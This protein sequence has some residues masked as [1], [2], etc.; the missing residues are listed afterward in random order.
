[1]GNPFVLF[2]LDWDVTKR[3]AAAAGRLDEPG[4]WTVTEWVVLIMLFA[5][6]AAILYC[7]AQGLFCLQWPDR[8]P[9]EGLRSVAIT[10]ATDEADANAGAEQPSILSRNQ[11][12]QEFGATRLARSTTRPPDRLAGD[13]PLVGEWNLFF[14]RF[15]FFGLIHLTA[16]VGV[17]MLYMSQVSYDRASVSN[18]VGLIFY[19]LL[20]VQLSVGFWVAVFGFGVN[21]CSKDPVVTACPILAKPVKPKLDRKVAILFPIYNEEVR[22]VLSGLEASMVSLCKACEASN[23]DV[24]VRRFDWH[25]LSD[26]RKADLSEEEAET[27]TAYSKF[28]YATRGVKVFYR[29]RE[30]NTNKKVGNIQE[31]LDRCGDHYDYMIIFDADSMMSGDTIIRMA[32]TICASPQVGII[33]VQCMPVRQ[34][35]LFGR[36]FQFSATM[37]GEMLVQGYSWV[38]LSAGTYIGHNAIINV[39]AFRRAAELPVLPGKPPLGGHILSHDHVEAAMMR[40]AGWEVWFLPSGDGSYEEIPTNL[41]DFI[42]RD[43]RW[44]T[45]ELQH[46][47]L[48]MM[49]GLPPMSRYQLTF[50]ATHYLGGITWIGLTLIGS[51]ALAHCDWK[52]AECPAQNSSDKA[53]LNGTIGLTLLLLFGSRFLILILCLLGKNRAPGGL[54]KCIIS[55]LIEVV[56]STCLAPIFSLVTLWSTIKILRGQGSGWNGQDREGAALP[57]STVLNKLGA[58]GLF[59]AIVPIIYFASNAPSAALASL[60]FFGSLIMAIPL[61]K[62]SS[63]PKGGA[64]DWTRKHNLFMSPYENPNVPEADLDACEEHLLKAMEEFEQK[65]KPEPEPEPPLAAL[66]DSSMRSNDISRSVSSTRRRRVKLSQQLSN[67]KSSGNI[68]T[69]MRRNQMLSVTREQRELAD[70]ILSEALPKAAAEMEY[71]GTMTALMEEESQPL[72]PAESSSAAGTAAVDKV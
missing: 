20:T 42:A 18:I 57:W 10:S 6:L 72:M 53:F 12:S 58:Y 28:C 47:K 63:A 54:F 26:T 7:M 33:Q 31:F 19:A 2:N 45:G 55:M 16:A 21:L 14:R 3:Q 48:I 46:L 39:A 51:N 13:E 37:F 59:S 66:A 50:A 60:P 49:K 44:L 68:H 41:I 67:W 69:G 5:A 4:Q 22:R 56:V 11:S 71:E 36:M 27:F 61:A 62:Y 40:R 30:K 38:L 24:P 29:R 17:W 15:L 34:A 65:Q 64:G 52:D 32:R 8:K 70:A 1:M 23:G 9:A 35:S 25:I 43:F